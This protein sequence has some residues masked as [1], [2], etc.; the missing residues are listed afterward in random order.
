MRFHNRR[1]IDF[2]TMAVT[3]WLLSK[4]TTAIAISVMRLQ[5][6]TLWFLAPYLRQFKIHIKLSKTCATAL[7]TRGFVD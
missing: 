2:L 5:E 7:E 4:K 6:A 1:G 3:S